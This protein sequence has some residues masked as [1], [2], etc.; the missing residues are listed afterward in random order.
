[1]RIQTSLDIRLLV[2]SSRNSLKS[3]NYTSFTNLL[4][5]V[6]YSGKLWKIMNSQLKCSPRQFKL[7]GFEEPV[8]M[9]EDLTSDD[10]N[11]VAFLASIVDRKLKDVAYLRCDNLYLAHDECR[12]V[13]LY[14]NSMFDDSENVMD[15]YEF[16]YNGTL[17]D[18]NYYIDEATLSSF[19]LAFFDK[20][21]EHHQ[22][23]KWYAHSEDA[24]YIEIQD[25]S[26]DCTGESF[27]HFSFSKF[28]SF[29]ELN[30]NDKAFAEFL[31]SILGRSVSDIADIICPQSFFDVM[32]EFHEETTV[33]LHL[34][35]KFNELREYEDV[36]DVFNFKCVFDVIDDDDGSRMCV[37]DVVLVYFS[38]GCY[39]KHYYEED[40]Y[41]CDNVL[42]VPISCSDLA[43]GGFYA[44][45]M[46]RE[47]ELLNHEEKALIRLLAYNIG[48]DFDDM[49]VLFNRVVDRDETR[50]SLTLKQRH[51]SSYNKHVDYVN[52]YKFRIGLR[53]SDHTGTI[54]DYAKLV[55][56]ELMVPD[57]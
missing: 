46:D 18:G 1:M 41:L 55:N 23:E 20:Y 16:T 40:E 45:H 33:E 3:D 29:D 25:K 48:E 43:L 21:F 53:Y 57:Y 26:N 35:T 49:E 52:T 54:F 22:L 14:F 27:D 42:D 19:K 10:E 13:R 30:A 56:Y 31:V 11:T 6:N 50:C 9:R 15:R 47:Y 7:I 37:T 8:L 4:M 38:L 5:E 39:A 2:N 44:W 28:N 34:R 36:H 32:Q 12:N 24:E 51:C 17:D